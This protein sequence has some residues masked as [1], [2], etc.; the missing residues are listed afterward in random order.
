MGTGSETAAHTHLLPRLKCTEFYFQLLMSLH[1]TL[2][3]HRGGSLPSVCLHVYASVY[4][5]RQVSVHWYFLI[6]IYNSVNNIN[7]INENNNEYSCLYSVICSVK[8]ITVSGTMGYLCV[9]TPTSLYTFHFHNNRKVAT[10]LILYPSLFK[11]DVILLFPPSVS[12]EF[13][14]LLYLPSTP[15][16][17]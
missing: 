6:N 4:V 13:L 5:Y 10:Y 16:A 12:T 15:F 7:N 8:E 17:I 14:I 9:S 3:R 1:N 11:C 2:L